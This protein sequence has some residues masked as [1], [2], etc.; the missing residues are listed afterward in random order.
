MD[1]YMPNS[2]GFD[3]IEALKDFLDVDCPILVLTGHATEDNIERAMAL[4]ATECISKPLKADLLIETIER[5]I[6]DFPRA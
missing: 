5:I 4:G 2:D 6:D 3:A 1:L